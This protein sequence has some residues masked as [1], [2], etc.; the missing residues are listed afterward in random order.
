MIT[1]E[2]LQNCVDNKKS[3]FKIIECKNYKLIISKYQFIPNFD[4]KVINLSGKQV[5]NWYQN[6]STF[7]T[8]NMIQEL[9]V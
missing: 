1:L 4:I 7:N 9:S 8:Y 5:I 2:V 3:F 6:L